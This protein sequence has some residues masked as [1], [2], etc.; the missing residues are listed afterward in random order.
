M[1]YQVHS[2]KMIRQRLLACHVK[3]KPA[4]AEAPAMVLFVEGDGVVPHMQ[5][6]EQKYK[7]QKVAVVHK[8]RK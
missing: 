5:R 6:H 7:E 2:H 4:Y 8:G 3:T 1:T